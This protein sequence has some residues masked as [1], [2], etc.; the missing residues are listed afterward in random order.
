MHHAL[1][2]AEIEMRK[3]GLLTTAVLLAA[4]GAIY[5]PALLAQ[6]PDDYGASASGGK[7]AKKSAQLFPKAK[8]AEPK[9][10]ISSTDMDVA[11][12]KLLAL[13]NTN[14]S[15]DEAIAAGEKIAANH[16]ANH[17]DRSVAYQAVGYAYLN[18][19]DNAKGVEYLQKSLAENALP[20]N[21]YYLLMLQMAKAQ[22]A[23]GQADAGLATLDRVIAE[24]EE[25][26]PE[27]SAIRGRVAYEKK[28]YA[29][30][31]AAFQKVIDSAGAKP[32]PSEQQMLLASY[33][34][35][36][37]PERAVKI[38]EDIAH[39]HPDDK[40]A[41]MNLA[42][43]YQQVGQS[44]KA[45]ATLDDARKR[46]LLTDASDY[47]KLYSLYSNIKGRENDSISVISE[48]LQKGILQPNAE[49]YTALA[50]DYYF[51]NQIP[52]AIDAYK[53]ADAASSG[54]EAALNLAKVYNNNGQAT[55]AKAAAERALQKG[56][57]HP[58]E[59]RGII[60]AAAA[61]PSKTGKKK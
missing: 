17:Y 44:E 26:K 31:A 25:D 10:G 29:A 52:Q 24:T 30:A 12:S 57:K 3:F 60:D 38:A 11:M 61:A 15:N 13:V 51:T 18:K 48:G 35:L 20:N 45:A 50:E 2:G 9:I 55:E 4:L 49:V 58:E 42:A 47:R 21:E 7:A 6:N 41:V 22:I 19:G 53:K 34:E 32:D 23:A 16:D 36:K 40:V 1:S 56:V 8:R 14:K 46:G 43:I 5:A 39:A 28:D 37:Q 27:Y 33:V 59:A 54:G